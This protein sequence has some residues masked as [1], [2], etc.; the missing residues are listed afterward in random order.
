MRPLCGSRALPLLMI[1]AAGMC[2]LFPE[3]GRAAGAHVSAQFSLSRED[4]QGMTSSLP[5]QIQAR[6]LARP[7]DFLQ[8]VAK[9]LDEPADFFLLVDKKHALPAGY[10]PADLVRL[11]KDYKLDVSGMDVSVRK[12]IMP[13]VLEMARAARGDGVTLVF[14]SGYRSYEYQITV[15][16]REVKLYGRETADRESA[17][18][19]MSQHQLGT[20]IDFGSIT[21]AFANTRAGKWLAA[22]AGEYGFSLS[23]PPGYEEL[24]G[25]RYESWHYRYITRAG[26]LMQREFFDDVQQYLVE[27]L[28][29]NRAALEAKRLAQN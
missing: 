4:L 12:A 2:L 5:R 24:T 14:S 27:F 25:Y 19:G 13:A 1:L 10:A 8:L 15:F 9:V 29:Q 20:A 3:P 23:Y 17:R 22:H 7:K 11:F 26:T 28:H 6:I 18:A 16:E 21:D